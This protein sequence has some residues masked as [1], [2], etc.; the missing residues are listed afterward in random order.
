[1]EL[2]EVLVVGNIIFSFLL[3]V[4]V[5]FVVAKSHLLDTVLKSL[6]KQQALGTKMP[7]FGPPMMPEMPPQ[8][9]G[10][11]PTYMG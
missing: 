9:P 7:G 10:K 5:I 11:Q 1:M 4:L 2:I 6:L 3:F 8:E